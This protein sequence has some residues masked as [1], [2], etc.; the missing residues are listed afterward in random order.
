[1]TLYRASKK[2]FLEDINNG[3]D[4][5]GFADFMTD[6]YISECGKEPNRKEIKSWQTS[7]PAMAKM[8]KKTHIPDD[9][10]IFIEYEIPKAVSKRHIDFMIV[11]KDDEGDDVVVIVE[12]KAWEFRYAND[13]EDTETLH[14]PAA[15][16]H[17]QILKYKEKLEQRLDVISMTEGRAYLMVPCVYLYKYQP[18][19][20]D[21][22]GDELVDLKNSKDMQDVEFFFK[23][24]Q[25][26]FAQML[27][28]LMT[29]D[30][31]YETI[32]DS[33]ES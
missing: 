22:P 13:E 33:L 9:T 2:E 19:L 12:L 7:L 24:E 20:K 4:A 30:T 14:T 25:D 31:E 10:Q 21:A 26:K 8:L 15:R 23:G 6:L 32:I 27:N 16:L 29:K 1:M 18:W 28:N 5:K 17:N 11:G 3:K